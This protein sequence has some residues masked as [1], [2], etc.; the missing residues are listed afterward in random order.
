[1]ADALLDALIALEREPT[2]LHSVARWHGFHQRRN[3]HKSLKDSLTS[4]SM[5]T[6]DEYENGQS[7]ESK[8]SSWGLSIKHLLLELITLTECC[9]K[10]QWRNPEQAF[11]IVDAKWHWVHD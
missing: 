8:L 4:P 9:A 1:V 7:I 3:I 2:K 6:D 5:R 11:L 10:V